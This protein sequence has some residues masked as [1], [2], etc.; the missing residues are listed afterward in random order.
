MRGINVF[1][2]QMEKL[3]HTLNKVSHPK[4]KEEEKRGCGVRGRRGGNGD[5]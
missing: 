2:L 1:I 3:R 5:G 4:R